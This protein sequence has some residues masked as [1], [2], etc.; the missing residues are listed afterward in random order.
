MSNADNGLDYIADIFGVSA[1][2]KKADE[3]QQ[4]DVIDFDKKVK[5]FN[6]QLDNESSK[7]L[8]E[9]DVF[10][11]E[12]NPTEEAIKQGIKK[13]QENE[14]EEEKIKGEVEEVPNI[15]E[16]SESEDEVVSDILEDVEETEKDRKQNEE[17]MD[18]RQ[19]NMDTSITTSQSS[20]HKWRLESTDQKYDS[21]YRQKKSL[22]N[23][24]LIDGPLPF[25]KLMNELRDSSIDLS[26]ATFDTEIVAKKMYHV[27][28]MRDRIKEI[29]I[30][31]NN[32]YFLWERSIELMHGL[33]ARTQYEK[34]AAKQDG[35]IYEHMEDMEIYFHRLKALHRS[36]EAVVKNLDGAF[37]CLSRRATI[38]M[39]TKQV[40]RKQYSQDQ[41]ENNTQSKTEVT[42]DTDDVL[43][44]D[45]LSDYDELPDSP[46]KKNVVKPI[47]PEKVSWDAL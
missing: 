20:G 16:E 45:S 13:S 2:M 28:Q 10:D 11:D 19:E 42:A 7:D 30:Q 47:R 9:L 34:P 36:A 1:E 29:Q 14:K 38:A 26:Y 5:D 41:E 31:C 4:E 25:D 35:L 44:P 37:E 40:E 22:L 12:K 39:P 32:Q 3:D 43:L 18:R 23:R 33:L 15:I 21:F 8:K 24:I 27:Q 46:S 6:Q 17:E